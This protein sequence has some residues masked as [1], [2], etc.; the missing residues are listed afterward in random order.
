MKHIVFGG[1]ALLTLMLGAGEA[2]AQDTEP[3][4]ASASPSP[5]PLPAVVRVHLRTYRD[6]SDARVYSRRLDNSW[7]LLCVLPCTADAPVGTELRVTMASSENEPHSYVVPG[8]LGPEMDLEVRP[9]S[10]GPLVGGIVM[11]G[12]GGAFVLS[13]LLFLALADL[14]KG[15]PVD[16]SGM[17][18]AGWVCIGLGA[19]AAVGGL[20]WLLTRSHE[21]RIMD[22]PRRLARPMVTAALT[23]SS[24]TSPRPARET[25]VQEVSYRLRSRRCASASRFDQA[26]LGT[27]DLRLGRR[28]IPALSKASSADV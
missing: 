21:P 23:L 12:S 1:A 7:S 2:A 15:S 3:P 22:T 26:T 17:K 14:S 4:P 18:T 5:S 28:G 19:A 20:V 10:V 9:A 13:G 6:K 16:N 27:G 11:M 8:D 24:V 25:T